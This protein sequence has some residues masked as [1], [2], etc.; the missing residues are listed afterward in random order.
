MQPGARPK[1]RGRGILRDYPRYSYQHYD[2]PFKSWQNWVLVT[3]L[4]C[5]FTGVNK[6]DYGSA[7][8]SAREDLQALSEYI[9]NAELYDGDAIYAA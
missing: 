4:C 1:G 8:V 5:H 2:S 9:D 6:C 7:V 3:S